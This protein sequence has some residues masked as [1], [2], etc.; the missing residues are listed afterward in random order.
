MLS[1]LEQLE[2]R[3]LLSVSLS[4]KG[5]LI[6]TGTSG[7]DVISIGYK[8]SRILV[9]DNG[10]ASSFSRRRG[11]D[12]FMWIFPAELTASPPTT[13]F[14]V[15]TL[16][17][18]KGDDTIR[19]GGAGEVINGQSGNDSINPGAGHFEISGGFGTDTA[20]FSDAAQAMLVN[21]DDNFNDGPINNAMSNAHADFEI[22]N[23]SPYAD[24]LTTSPYLTTIFGNGGDDKIQG[25]ASADSLVGGPG[26]D[27]L[28]GSDSDD[29]VIGGKGNDL[30]GGGSGSDLVSGGE[31]QPGLCSFPYGLIR[32]H[33]R[34]CTT[35]SV[36]GNRLAL[37]QRQRR[38]RFL[39]RSR[40]RF[41][42]RRRCRR[43]HAR[44]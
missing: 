11:A 21:L 33:G 3:R 32:P 43:N 15:M 24:E 5:T 6:L 23:G 34:R 28:D 36:A 31:E 16:N 8:P 20:D 17:G 22:I 7:K 26:D 44:R 39:W 25:R 2:I 42:V 30:V 19:G 12:E 4:S 18:G 1:A 13:R 27:T 14:W 41:P 35:G 9:N 40:Q 10:I 29:T 37:C 38:Q